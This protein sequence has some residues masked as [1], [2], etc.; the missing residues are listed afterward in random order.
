MFVVVC[1]LAADWLSV[2]FLLPKQEN[3]LH[4]THACFM[5]HFPDL[6]AGPVLRR[7]ILSKPLLG[8][9]YVDH[10]FVVSLVVD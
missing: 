2:V 6:C 8:R 4:L 7:A 9:V 3:G 1:C 5:I 10:V